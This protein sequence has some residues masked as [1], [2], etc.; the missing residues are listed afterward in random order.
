MELP[1]F[2]DGDVQ[3]KAKRLSHDDRRRTLLVLFPTCPDLK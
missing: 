2:A 1:A 3:G